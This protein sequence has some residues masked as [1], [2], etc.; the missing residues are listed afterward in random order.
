[1]KY[2]RYLNLIFRANLTN[3]ER[4]VEKQLKQ[5]SSGRKILDVGCGGAPY[6]KYCS[7][8]VYKTHDFGKLNGK[9]IIN[10]KYAKL[11]YV[12]DICLIPEKDASF[13]AILCT[14]VLEHVSEPIKAV[15]EMARLL[16]PGGVLILTAP[17]GSFLHQTPYHFYGGYTPYWFKK[18]LP[19]AGFID[20]QIESNG[21]FFRFFGQECQRVTRIIFRRRPLTSFW[22]WI[23]YPLKVFP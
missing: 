19:E 16:K 9:Q 22:R 14:E 2:K 6:R 7:H 20:I 21:G 11:D 8:L 15:N 18:F 4:W 10:G 5:I 13:D 23:F 17:L 1:M 3:R 12:S